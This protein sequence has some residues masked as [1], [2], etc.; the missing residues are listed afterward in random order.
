M[1]FAIILNKYKMVFAI[2][3]HYICICHYFSTIWKVCNAFIL[4]YFTTKQTKQKKHEV[5]VSIMT[6][7][8]KVFDSLS[9]FLYPAE[10]SRSCSRAHFALS[11]H[12]IFAQLSHLRHVCLELTVCCV[13]GTCLFM[14]CENELWHLPTSGACLEHYSIYKST[15][16]VS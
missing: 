4:I 5:T 6:S 3:K 11:C 14:Q 1:A 8:K 15:C 16:F 9:R 7:G 10:S 2:G 12:S 13:Y